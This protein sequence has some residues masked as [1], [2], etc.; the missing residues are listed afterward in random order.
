MEAISKQKHRDAGKKSGEK[1]SLVVAALMI[2]RGI[3]KERAVMEA[4]RLQEPPIG[5]LRGRREGN[6]LKLRTAA[7]EVGVQVEEEPG[8]RY[9][10]PGCSRV[11]SAAVASTASSDSWVATTSAYSGSCFL[12]QALGIL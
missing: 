2:N 10:F 6:D 5:R 4:M 9:K 1:V 11:P 8:Q 12:K 7:G 3:C